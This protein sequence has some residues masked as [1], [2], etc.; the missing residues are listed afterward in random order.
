MKI[1]FKI[2]FNIWSCSIIITVVCACLC[3]AC[4]RYSNRYCSQLPF[5]II[6]IQVLCASACISLLWC[7]NV[8]CI[9][10][11]GNSSSKKKIHWKT[12][13]IWNLMQRK[14]SNFNTLLLLL[15]TARTESILSNFFIEV[16][17]RK[18]AKKYAGIQLNYSVF[19]EKEADECYKRHIEWQKL[20]T[21]NGCFSIDKH[22]FT[23]C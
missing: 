15:F 11:P 5:T 20:W 8:Q 2:M 14:S 4:S 13:Q 10:Y 23:V 6:D 7:Y 9:K 18:T 3:I 12:I 22:P 19:D 17:K 16:K 1:S 21:W